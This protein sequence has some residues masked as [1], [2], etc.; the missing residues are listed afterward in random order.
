MGLHRCC[1]FEKSITLFGFGGTNCFII[2]T[3]ETAMKGEGSNKKLLSSHS[4]ATEHLVCIT[5]ILVSNVVISF[6]PICG[7]RNVRASSFT[8]I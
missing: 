8:Q 7:D 1:F 2:Q 4:I 5:K 6:A 3:H